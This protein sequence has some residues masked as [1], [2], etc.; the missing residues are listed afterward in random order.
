[1]RRVKVFVSSP[2]DVPQ[3][4]RRL[5]DIVVELNGEFANK[6]VFEL[7]LWEEDIYS[8]S[9]TYQ[10][11]IPPTAESDILLSIF[12]SRLGTPLKPSFRPKRIDGSEFPGGM[13]GSVYE[14]LTAVDAA[15]HHGQPHI[16]VFRK[17]AAAQ[18]DVA[19]M[20]EFQRASAE[21]RKVDEF[22]AA[23]FESEADGLKP[24]RTFEDT[25]DFEALVAAELRAWVK[26]NVLKSRFATTARDVPFPGLAA[27]DVDQARY[28]FGRARKVKAAVAEL[29]ANAEKGL[30]LLFVVGPSG[31]GKSSL[32]RAGIAP[33]LTTRGIVDGVELWRIGAM[34]PG[35]AG[36][37]PFQALAESL[38]G[39]SSGKAG[40]KRTGA[41]PELAA[42]GYGDP[43]VLADRL[44][45]ADDTSAAPI[46]AVLD[47]LAD[48]KR[49][50]GGYGRDVGANLLLLVDQFEDIFASAVDEETRR[51][52]V[53]LLEVLAR[54]GRIWVVATL[55]A[56]LLDKM[57]QPPLIAVYQPA[58]K[59]LLAPPGES[60]LAEI[61]EKTAEAVDVAY[62][63]DP[64]TGKSL[65]EV[66]LEDSRGVDSLPLLSFAL[67]ELY[68]RR[69]ERDG[70]Q[71]F[72]FE[73]YRAFGGISG[74]IDS[75]ATQALESAFGKPAKGFDR[76]LERLLRLLVVQV[77]N[78][79]SSTV[80]R[81]ALS[82]HPTPVADLPND[83]VTAQLVEALVS[84]RILLADRSGEGET[85][86]ATLRIAHERVLESWKLARDIVAR[87]KE[88]FQTRG[89]VVDQY[90]LW[91]QS[92][93]SPGELI[94]SSVSLNAAVQLKKRY[95]DELPPELRAF[96][97]RSVWRA[98][99]WKVIYGCVAAVL[100]ALA[101]AAGWL[102]YRSQQNYE[103][104]RDQ[105]GSLV[106]QI[107]T[108]LEDT[109]GIQVGAVDAMLK[110]VRGSIERLAAGNE[111]PELQRVRG[112]MLYRFARIY[113]KIGNRS[114]TFSN[115]AE[116]SANQSL[117][118]RSALAAAD[119]GQYDMTSELAEAYELIGDINRDGKNYPEA[120]RNQDEAL[121][122][123]QA[124]LTTHPGDP[125]MRIALSYS[126]IRLG[127]IA[128][129]EKQFD[130]A[131]EKY[132]TALT[133]TE[134]LSAEIA[135]PQ[136]GQAFEP[137]VRT[138]ALRELTWG[139]NKIGSRYMRAADWPAAFR[140]FERAACVR[141]ALAQAETGNAKARDDFAFSLE[142]LSKVEA[143][144]PVYRQLAAFH[145]LRIRQQLAESDPYNTNWTY[146]LAKS[147]AN[148]GTLK[149]KLNQ[150]IFALAF[151]FRSRAML[152]TL[153]ENRNFDDYRFGADY[154]AVR[155]QYEETAARL[156]A[157]STVVR[158][159]ASFL[160]PL[161]VDQTALYTADVTFASCPDIGRPATPPSGGRI[162]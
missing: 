40:G 54:T 132:K 56:D 121:S 125:R 119:A 52:F 120:R 8:A 64:E 9:R 117:A 83:P 156:R 108:R 39:Q 139:L 162:R 122:L 46:V 25:D 105:V 94:R 146:L 159:D 115:D 145:S 37:S 100:V 91:T 48:G 21:W 44:R 14:L 13:T 102:G 95:G 31:A 88:F 149:T 27:Y 74:A 12:W 5:Q 143:Q 33:Q 11:Q 124:L 141:E 137:Q 30:P 136:K 29:K 71:T 128:V 161:I 114:G 68:A 89:N 151:F 10:E 19:N 45:A 130:Q 113:R 49:A 107:A 104:A 129:D 4:R 150:D 72:P 26:K 62:G 18:T 84:A 126:N 35:G 70:R 116:I 59:Y 127:D 106:T 86:E 92:R 85:G 157:G 41:L 60:E 131:M 34:R 43:A 118:I 77:V 67:K 50:A 153:A 80:G 154:A 98:R 97:D 135:D 93:Q 134:G 16:C 111:D 144:G 3:E 32:M 81:E 138:E 57:I 99:F 87:E 76:Q 20:A 155:E 23:N 61:I 55:R 1:M 7:Y 22:F 90:R 82:V 152:K 123:R 15:N 66:L 103:V 28:Y 53:R 158:D 65:D 42:A 58:A 17:K 75:S 140:Y 6:V 78:S 96:I 47:G 79:R 148:V 51:A 63:T 69:V 38:V 142:N 110:V 24:Y 112:S 160:E 147:Y 101:G 109:Y 133:F 2:S 73:E 36:F